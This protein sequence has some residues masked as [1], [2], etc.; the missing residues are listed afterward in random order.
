MRQK[1]PVMAFFTFVEALASTV[2]NHI[3]NRI[4]SKQCTYEEVLSGENVK[5]DV[6]TV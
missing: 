3:N 5:P 6:S 4:I 1:E 2:Y